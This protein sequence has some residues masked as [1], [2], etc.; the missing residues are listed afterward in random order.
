ME[1]YIRKKYKLSKKRAK[2]L[3][4][5]YEKA[6]KGTTH[7]YTIDEFIEL[8]VKILPLTHKKEK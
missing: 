4:K 5:E 6:I 3:I 7:K 8:V 1:K 2:L